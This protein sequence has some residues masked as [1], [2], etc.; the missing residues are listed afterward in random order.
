MISRIYGS[1]DYG[2]HHRQKRQLVYCDRDKNN[3][4]VSETKS[5]CLVVNVVDWLNE[6]NDNVLKN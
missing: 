5:K 1:M 4:A 3:I 6:Y 2:R